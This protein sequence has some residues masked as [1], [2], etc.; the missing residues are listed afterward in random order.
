MSEHK[1]GR[2]L[3]RPAVF[4]FDDLNVGSANSDRDGFDQDRAFARIRLG[5]IFVAGGLGFLWFYSDGFHRSSP[6]VVTNALFLTVSADLRAS[7]SPS[8]FEGRG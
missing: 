7:H 8:R 5:K 1:A 6:W 3:R 4:P 2:S